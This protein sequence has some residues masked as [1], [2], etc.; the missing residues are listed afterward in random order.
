M[1]YIYKILIDTREKRYQHIE[2]HFREKE[3]NYEFRKLDIGDYQIEA[4]LENGEIYIP[5]IAIERKANLDELLQNLLEQQKLRNGKLCTRIE[6]ELMRAFSN[7][8]DLKIIIQDNLWF[9]NIEYHN[10]RT[11]INVPFAKALITDIEAK[12]SPFVSVQGIEKGLIG[13][14]ILLMLTRQL[15]YE[16]E[17]YSD[18]K[19]F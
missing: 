17:L 1:N 5:K 14:K 7:K 10:F 16:L 6:A 3:V 13:D 2:T 15:K 8:I 11:N 18:I 19:G 9:R 12:Y 4:T